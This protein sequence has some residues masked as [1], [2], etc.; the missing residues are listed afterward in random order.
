M[1]EEIKEAEFDALVD[2]KLPG[3]RAALAAKVTNSMGIP[4][5]IL[6][7]P[8]GLRPRWLA[9]EERLDEVDA[10]IRRYVQAKKMVP[11]EWTEEWN[12]LYSRKEKRD[13]EVSQKNRRLCVKFR[14]VLNDAVVGE[15]KDMPEIQPPTYEGIVNWMSHEGGYDLAQLDKHGGFDSHLVNYGLR[16]QFWVPNEEDFRQEAMKAKEFMK[17][18]KEGG[19]GQGVIQG[20]VVVCKDACGDCGL[21]VGKEYSIV[22]YLDLG[23]VRVINDNGEERDYF[24]DRFHPEKAEKFFK[25]LTELSV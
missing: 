18:A 11:Q 1:K 23:M 3:V 16:Q 7:P 10:A 24:Q 19:Y 13:R 22:T 25:R 12:Y 6:E 21:T 17:E 4:K 20:R 2:Q 9:E 15:W 14:S 5:E 8:L